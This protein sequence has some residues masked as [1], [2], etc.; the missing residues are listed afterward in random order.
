MEGEHGKAILITNFAGIYRAQIVDFDKGGVPEKMSMSFV[1][2][3]K[4]YQI[5]VDWHYETGYPIYEKELTS[6][7]QNTWKQ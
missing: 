4:V 7:K 6:K 1:N 2:K 3:K 5:A